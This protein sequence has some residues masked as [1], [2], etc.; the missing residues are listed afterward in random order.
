MASEVEI[1][2]F[3][4]TLLGESR[5]ASMDDDVKPAR[6]AKAVFTLTRDSLLSA[7]DWSFAKTRSQIPALSDAPAFGYSLQYQLPSDCLRILFVG[8]HYAGVDLTD[9]RSAP[10]EEFELEDRKIITDMAAPLNLRY[11]KRVTDTA[12]FA[13]NFVTSFSAKLAEQLAEPLTQSDTKRARAEKA[14]STAISLAIRANAIEL[15]PKRL[16]DD[17]W[18]MSRL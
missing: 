18:L 10:T 4:L 15:P 17:D 16:A 13:P 6:E 1:V 11:V 8:D 9:Y 2:N 3:A 7:Y 5:I 14:F 12:Q